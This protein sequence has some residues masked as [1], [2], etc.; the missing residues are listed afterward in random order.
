MSAV[1]KKI[2]KPG[3]AKAV[4]E[5]LGGAAAVAMT[6][7]GGAGGVRTQTAPAGYA[8]TVKQ[9][10]AGDQ[11]K[12]SITAAMGR[13]NDDKSD[14]IAGSIYKSAP[15]IV[16][17]G[18]A[19]EV[20]ER[21]GAA[22]GGGGAA[23]AMTDTGGAGGVRPSTVPVGYVDAVKAKY[24]A[25]TQSADEERSHSQRAAA[26]A[27]DREAKATAEERSHSQRAAARAAD[28]EAAA[29]AEAEA[30]EAE[31]AAAQKEAEDRAAWEKTYGINSEKIRDDTL[32]EIHRTYE[33]M[34]AT[35]GTQAENLRQRGLSNSGYAAVLERVMREQENA[36]RAQAYA[37]YSANEAKNAQG[38]A[39]YK[40]AQDEKQK[41]QKL[42]A[43]QA[44]ST[45]LDNYDN[46][47]TV[48]KMLTD[49]YGYDA[50]T[51]DAI[52][53][54]A[55]SFKESAASGG[56]TANYESTVSA[57]NQLR[58][59]GRSHEQAL[60]TM[61][62]LG[63]YEDGDLNAID[64][65]YT[66]NEEWSAKQTE[67]LTTSLSGAISAISAGNATDAYAILK[68]LGDQ[69]LIAAY[70]DA[71]ND[72]NK[73]IMAIY[74][75][76]DALYNADPSAE[77]AALLNAVG[78]ERLR[79]NLEKVVTNNLKKLP[80]AVA[81]ILDG[82]CNDGTDTAKT[83]QLQII[84]DQMQITSVKNDGHGVNDPSGYSGVWI[85]MNFLG[86]D[87]EVRADYYD[88][89][90]EQEKAI[91]EA[92]NNL[93]PNAEAGATVTVKDDEGRHLCISDGM[94]GW[95]WLDAKGD[96]TNSMY[97]G[98]DA[99]NGGDD[100]LTDEEW[101]AMIMVMWDTSPSVE[102]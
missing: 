92:A 29:A 42:E 77:N 9:R 15:G 62:K 64:K 31:A 34:S 69:N 47:D 67:T 54:D 71:G 72:P 73:Q 49:Y 13:T 58:S 3:Y 70:V 65:E 60:E 14:D 6:D 19:K 36:A 1:K 88:G 8:D 12:A 86:K 100:D 74:N 35:Y 68:K 63:Y 56:I 16:K 21:L 4:G 20:E 101:E 26:R 32:A 40:D 78:V 44:A 57:Y 61:R 95:Y 50:E 85:G 41:A 38:Y 52:I 25:N 83:E 89:D 59:T 28:R 5:K 91:L 80:D 33:R 17:P 81:D 43:L 48:K 24:D 82:K 97:F 46:P 30:A 39:Q 75:Y 90:T 55:Q 93:I 45:L 84:R 22:L 53:A 11:A 76:A 10:Y 18:Y 7:T 23:T 2:I 96:I 66:V 99:L 102:I 98:K 37:D 94:G 51:V 27:A 87:I 79:T